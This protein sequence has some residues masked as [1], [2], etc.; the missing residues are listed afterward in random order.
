MNIRGS[1]IGP[2]HTDGIRNG[3]VNNATRVS[4]HDSGAVSAIQPSHAAGDRVEISD[5]ARSAASD[6]QA[7]DVAFARKALLGIPPLSQDRISEI[8]QRVQEGYYSNDPDV[9]KHIAAQLGQ[10]LTGTG[11]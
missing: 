7:R 5:A 4:G 9:L 8:M 11:F 1:N 10:D 2:N 3:Y 6:A